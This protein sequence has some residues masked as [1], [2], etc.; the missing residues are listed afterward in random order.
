MSHSPVTPPAPPAVVLDLVALT[1]ELLERSAP[2]LRALAREGF[3]ATLDEPLPAVT[4][5]AQSTM[6]TGLL[7]RDHGIVGNGWYFRD[8]AEILFWRQSNA[9]VCGEK[10]WDALR[11]ARPGATVA[12]LFW[13]FNMYAAVDWSVTPRPHYP[14][15]G[16]KIP[17]IYTQ[18]PALERELEEALGPFPLFDFWGPR[19]GLRSS[20]WIAACALRIFEAFRPALTLVYL[21][22]LDYDLQRFGPQSE[23]AARATAEIDRLASDLIERVRAAGGRA[24]VVSEYGIEPVSRPVHLNRVLREAGF[25]RVRESR[26]VGETLD[27]GASRAFAVAD[28]QVAHVYV[29]APEDE[30]A[31]RALLLAT[32]GVA[33]VLGAAEKREVGLDHPRAGELVAVAAPGAW[34]TYYY[35]LDDARAPDFARTVDIHR[36][37]GYDPVELFFAPGAR[38]KL[39]LAL[40]LLQKAAGFRALL[41]V[42]PLDATLVRGSHGRPAARPEAGPLVL[43]HERALAPAA[44]GGAARIPMAAVRDLILRAAG[45]DPAGAPPSPAPSP[46]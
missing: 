23:E 19:A 46:G 28:H 1:P 33:R 30:A 5:T 43:S 15:D 26:F 34:F 12:Q 27:A 18:P 24:I 35:W 7:P 29:R 32:P 2:C 17:G 36:K 4:S 8:L 6:L 37:P 40:R 21:P 44:A 41:D 45:A 14:A 11:R 38:T 16:R 20:E 42:I 25:L 31:V 22:H 9:L 10:V 3:L 39:R 13:W